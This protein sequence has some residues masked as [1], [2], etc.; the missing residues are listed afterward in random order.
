M[1]PVFIFI[2]SVIVL[3]LDVLRGKRKRE[4]LTR[5]ASEKACTNIGS[6]LLSHSKITKSTGLKDIESRQVLKDGDSAWIRGYV[7]FTPPIVYHGCYE[8][9]NN[10]F[11]E[12]VTFQSQ[13]IYSCVSYCMNDTK[14]KHFTTEV[15]GITHS[16][17]LCLNQM[18]LNGMRSVSDS[19]CDH[20]ECSEFDIDSCGGEGVVSVYRL[21]KSK[22]IPWARNENNQGQCINVKLRDSGK[23]IKAYTASCYEASTKSS[24]YF[25]QK[26]AHS[27]LYRCSARDGT[28][29]YC[30]VT[31]ASSRQEAKESCFDHKGVLADLN[32][33]QHIMELMQSNTYYWIGI[34]RAYTVTPARTTFSSACLAVTKVNGSLYFDP[35]NCDKKKFFLCEIAKHMTTT[36]TAESDKVRTTKRHK[37][38]EILNATTTRVTSIGTLLYTPVSKI[39]T[40][41]GEQIKTNS[42]P[43]TQKPTT[44]PGTAKDNFET[45]L[46][47]NIE[48]TK[49]I[50][51]TYMSSKL[52]V[53]NDTNS[54]SKRPTYYS[55]VSDQTSSVGIQEGNRNNRRDQLNLTV[56][57]T[58]L[59][60]R[61]EGSSNDS[62]GITYQSTIDTLNVNSHTS[63]SDLYH[64]TTLTTVITV[65]VSIAVIV[66]T[67]VIIF[68]VVRKKC[69]HNGESKLKVKQA[70]K[71]NIE[72]YCVVDNHL[73]IQA[74]PF[75]KSTDLPMNVLNTPSSQSV[76][77][78]VPEDIV[79]VTSHEPEKGD[80]TTSF[81]LK[82]E[83]QAKPTFKLENRTELDDNQYDTLQLNNQPAKGRNE[84][85]GMGVQLNTYDHGIAG[86]N[87]SN[88][89]SANYYILEAIEQ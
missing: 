50:G 76:V 41:I 85:Y 53:I 38:D 60:Q 57:V 49:A 68:L 65:V 55:Y 58:E 42:K 36:I 27:L 45:P 26:G 87:Y 83:K 69:N 52:N 51:T 80:L 1:R 71:K 22:L 3:H 73:V 17:C 14:F 8:G 9:K 61:T 32:S 15:F 86:Q 37:T 56:D 12:F 48:T 19:R 10:R 75:A 20:S 18:D 72:T 16:T 35:D 4:K 44:M 6:E 79:R 84:T 64:D 31:S 5:G 30:R 7:T 43:L 24:G 13:D 21:Y 34:H 39:A 11:V 70:R 59:N 74:G 2:L 78:D 33:E 67:V 46:G 63:G 88:S 66:V 62:K 29:R 89:G 40:A 47:P 77:Y 54:M 28:G 23:R 25:C 82:T 81:K